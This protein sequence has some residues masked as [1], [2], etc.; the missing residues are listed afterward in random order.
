MDM[1]D[2]PITKEGYQRV[3]EELNKLKKIERPDIIKK[4][5]EA[6]S[7]GDL[8]ENA[9][10]HAARERQSFIEGRIGY[11]E[12]IIADSKV[13]DP[14]TF[15]GTKV[16]FGATVT[17]LDLNTDEETRYKIVSEV[18]SDPKNGKISVT[19][20]IGRALIGKNEGD[21]LKVQTPSGI[22]EYEVVEVQFI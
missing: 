19:S 14:L 9:E 22:K 10:Y 2:I 1:A 20:P 4:I 15:S 7:H 17:I 16:L 12:G 6:R 3:V 11:L 5:A 21:E 18:E 13:I 8:K